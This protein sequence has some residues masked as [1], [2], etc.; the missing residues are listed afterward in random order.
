MKIAYFLLNLAYST[1]VFNNLG[2]MRSVSKRIPDQ[3]RPDGRSVGLTTE[4]GRLSLIK[5][6]AAAETK[7]V[8]AKDLAD[9]SLMATK[10]RRKRLVCQNQPSKAHYGINVENTLFKNI[11]L[12]IND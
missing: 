7:T 5:K 11:K 10:R 6:R 2:F 12:I 9:C 3:V 1:N 4:S 8:I